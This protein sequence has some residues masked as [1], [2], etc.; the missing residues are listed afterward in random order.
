MVGCYRREIRFTELKYLILA[1]TAATRCNDKSSPSCVI[2][3]AP[4]SFH[5]L[6]LRAPSRDHRS[7]TSEAWNG[8]WWGGDHMH[9]NRNI[10]CLF[11]S[12]RV[13]SLVA[14]LAVFLGKLIR[15]YLS[16][17]HLGVGCSF[18]F[19]PNAWSVAKVWCEI[20]RTIWGS[21]INCCCIY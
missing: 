17:V 20:K 8:W 15:A 3:S 13:L 7:W 2:P 14:R 4:W 10:L 11:K 19:S 21:E 12:R 5:H 6:G 18:L 1:P 16:S 9:S